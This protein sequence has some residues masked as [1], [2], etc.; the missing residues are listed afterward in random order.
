M[1]T[2]K[3]LAGT[4]ADIA[5]PADAAEVGEF[6]AG[7]INGTVLV[8]IGDKSVSA[9]AIRHSASQTI[10]ALGFVG[11]YVT[12]SK[13]WRASVTYSRDHT[14]AWF[15]RDDRA[16]RFNKNQG[17]TWNPEAFYKIN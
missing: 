13:N 15:G 11:R 1:A 14:H 12:G 8:Q 3:I 10:S 17:I 7:V 16:G 6:Y 9:Y 5:T 4:F 2:I